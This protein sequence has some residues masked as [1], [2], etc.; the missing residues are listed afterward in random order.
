MAEL[1]VCE[2]CETAFERKDDDYD[3]A[4]PACGTRYYPKAGSC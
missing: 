3:A 2:Q 1:L 4:C